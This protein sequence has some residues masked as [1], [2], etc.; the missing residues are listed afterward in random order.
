[1]NKN[2][3]YRYFELNVNLNRTAALIISVHNL[4]YP[5]SSL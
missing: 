3:C 1:M 4:K 5:E 2:K